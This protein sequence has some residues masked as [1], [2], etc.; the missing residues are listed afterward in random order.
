MLD[1]LSKQYVKLTAHFVGWAFLSVLIVLRAIIL[2]QTPWL[3]VS[4]C[5]RG[6]CAFIQAL[7]VSTERYSRDFM[8][9]K[10]TQPGFQVCVGEHFWVPFSVATKLKCFFV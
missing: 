5:R 6:S 3:S 4:Q 7:G 1:S 2:F 8:W 10:A 9:T